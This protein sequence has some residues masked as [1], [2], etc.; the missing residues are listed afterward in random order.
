M[1]ITTSPNQPLRL[2]WNT[3]REN[4]HNQQGIIP[5]LNPLEPKN[6]ATFVGWCWTTLGDGPCDPGDLVLFEHL[7]W[8][9]DCLSI[10]TRGADVKIQYNASRNSTNVYLAVKKNSMDVKFVTGCPWRKSK[11]C[12]LQVARRPS[13]APSWQNHA[14]STISGEEVERHPPW[15]GDD[16]A[17]VRNELDPVMGS[18]CMRKRSPFLD[19]RMGPHGLKS[20]DSGWRMTHGPFKNPLINGLV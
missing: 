4:R 9:V 5:T 17:E 11:G 8:N 6:P 19:W 16:D 10:R 2:C 13:G 15:Y 3:N 18:W 1:I 12:N 7:T 14:K 20:M